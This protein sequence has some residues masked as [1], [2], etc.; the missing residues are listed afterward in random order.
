[1]KKQIYQYMIELTN[2]KW[3]SLLLKKIARSPVSKYIV[4]SY[5][6]VFEIDTIQTLKNKKDFTSLHDF[7]IREL[8]PEHRLIDDGHQS[9]VSPVDAKVESMGNVTDE[10]EF[11]VKG[12]N[13][14]LTRL[15]AKPEYLDTFLGGD[16][17][18]LYL[19]PADYHRIHSPLDGEVIDQYRSGTKSYPVNRWGLEYGK[20]P[21]SDNFRLIS[22][23]N[24][25]NQHVAVIKVGAMFVNSIELTQQTSKWE[26][27]K[28]VAYFGFG[29]TVVLLFEKNT[30]EWH[31][32][33]V[34]GKKVQ[35]GEPLGYML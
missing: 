20:K 35:V 22:I 18:V 24:H 14:S 2:T 15:L 12:Q 23:L 17:A 30:F 13:Y 1:M 3:S 4:P 32:D 31:P 26:K 34:A 6:K 29:S 28:E 25:H 8:K 11:L 5:S 7:F 21:I 10:G 9:V 16:Y 27:G 19:S 33:V